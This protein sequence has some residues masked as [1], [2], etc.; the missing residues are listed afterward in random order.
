MSLLYVLLRIPSLLRSYS[1]QEQ[2]A[3]R[4]AGGGVTKLR[5]AEQRVLRAAMRRYREWSE[6]FPNAGNLSKV[7]TSPAGK[8]MIRA[9]RALAKLE[10][11]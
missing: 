9:C 1:S 2:A 11:K 10:P 6:L 5:A 4:Q 3:D 8:A 7:R